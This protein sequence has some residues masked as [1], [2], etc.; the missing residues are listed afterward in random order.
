M[1]NEGELEELPSLPA[2]EGQEHSNAYWETSDEEEPQEALSSPPT[3]G[4]GSCDPEAPQMIS[5]EEPE[6]VLK[7]L[8]C[9]GE[10][11]GSSACLEMRDE[12]EPQ[13]DLSLPPESGSVSGKVETL[14][15]NR[16]EESE[17]LISSLL[18]YDG[19]G[20]EL[21]AYG[22]QKCSCVMCSSKDVPEGPEA[23]TASSQA[24]DT[25][26][27]VDLGNNSSSGK[28]KRKRSKSA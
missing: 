1:T 16:E 12:E 15:M 9:D 11:E 24:R 20:A 17:E 7:Q 18:T 19:Q 5:E 14:Q 25:M 21:P 3:C 28:L 10:A 4:R 8:L 26:D 13:E 6:E 2:E 27:T 23:S 22:N